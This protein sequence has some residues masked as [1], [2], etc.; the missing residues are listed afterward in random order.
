MVE[1]LGLPFPFLSDPDRRLAI[2]PFEVADP[3]DERR[4]ARP[5]M[6]LLTPDGEEAWRFVSRDFADRLPEQEVLERA[7]SLGLE[8]TRQDRPLRG[9][10]APGP[11][12]L[13]LDYLPG[14]YRGARFAALAMGLRHAQHSESIKND[15][16]A[17]VEEMDRYTEAVR[18]LLSD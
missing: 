8:P 3:K 5:A 6:I 14:Y 4:L 15:S 2:E 1:K 12:A 17:Y 18:R 9:E 13:S 11:R 7:R 16:K 10:P